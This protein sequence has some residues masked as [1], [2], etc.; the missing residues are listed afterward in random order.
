MA[1]PVV[2]AINATH[3][4]EIMKLSPISIYFVWEG[5]NKDLD[6]ALVY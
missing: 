4:L 2:R 1:K 6:A 5:F 3:E